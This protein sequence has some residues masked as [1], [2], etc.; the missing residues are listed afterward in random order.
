MNGYRSIQNDSLAEP[1][2]FRV[3]HFV[4]FLYVLRC[5]RQRLEPE[6]DT[7]RP[8]L[9]SRH[10]RVP[11]QTAPKQTAASK[12]YQNLTASCSERVRPCDN[13]NEVLDLEN[14]LNPF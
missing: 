3:I 2:F 12:N 1:V 7:I 11:G 13:L 6:T 14:E 5:N 10:P 9:N 8:W 4:I